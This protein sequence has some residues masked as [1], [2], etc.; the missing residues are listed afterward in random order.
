MENLQTLNIP[1]DEEF[2]IPIRFYHGTVSVEK[3]VGFKIKGVA[4]VLA[5]DVSNPEE[6]QGDFRRKLMS[7]AVLLNGD[8]IGTDFFEK[9]RNIVEDIFSIQTGP[10]PHLS[11]QGFVD[12]GV[13]SMELIPLSRSKED[14]QDTA[15]YNE[16]FSKELE[17]KKKE[18]SENQPESN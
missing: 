6:L 16:I 17:K 2:P 11:L 5:E 15:F 9:H 1:Y 12:F 4:T 8:I 7:C 18:T 13:E 3:V 10:T 14:K